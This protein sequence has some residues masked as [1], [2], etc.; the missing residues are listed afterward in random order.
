MVDAAAARRH[1]DRSR[2]LRLG[3]AIAKPLPGHAVD[4]REGPADHHVMALA[5]Q[6]GHYVGIVVVAQVEIGFVDEAG[7]RLRRFDGERLQLHRV[8][9]VAG[10]IVRVADIGRRRPGRDLFQ[11]SIEVDPEIG[12]QRRHDQLG[13]VLLHGARHAFIGGFRRDQLALALHRDH[14]A[15]CREDR[16]RSVREKNLVGRHALDLRDLRFQLFTLAVGIARRHRGLLDHC[17]DRFLGRTKRALIRA[18]DRHRLVRDRRSRRGR[19][20]RHSFGP[21]AASGEGCRPHARHAQAAQ[22]RTAGCRRRLRNLGSWRFRKGVGVSHRSVLQQR[23]VL[24]EA[25]GQGAKCRGAPRVRRC[26]RRAFARE[27]QRQTSC[28]TEIKR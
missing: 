27:S 2:K 17:S 6:P 1:R 20:G 7:R 22:Q 8:D 11:H 9:H 4:L 10:R 14:L 5:D 18:H 24:R 21:G 19:R 3:N 16:G 13:F 25:H 12:R 26:H 23:A 15:E 28:R